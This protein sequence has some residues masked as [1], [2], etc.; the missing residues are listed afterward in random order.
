MDSWDLPLLFQIGISTS[1]L[2]TED[3]R[4]TIAADALHPSDDY[5]SVNLGTELAY[6]DFLF[7]RGGFQSLWLP[8]REGGLC[9]GLGLSSKS[10]LSEGMQIRFD[11]AFRDMGRLDN[12]HVFSLGVRF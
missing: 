5:E 4:W 7:V 11:Y 9:L 8:D 10:F 3:L 6:Q 1:P 2:K 12:V